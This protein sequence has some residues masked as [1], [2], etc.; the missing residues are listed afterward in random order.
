MCAAVLL[1]TLA[2]S[3]VLTGCKKQESST[4]S[5]DKATATTQAQTESPTL[6]TESPSVSPTDND[7]T[8]KPDGSN[9]VSAEATA[10]DLYCLEFATYSGEFFEDGKNEVVN[11]VAM[12]LVQNRSRQFLDQA[13][14]TYIYGNEY[15]TFVVTGLPAGEKCW[16]MEKNKLTLE[17]GKSFFFEDCKTSFRS[18]VI[19]KP[20]Q[21]QVDTKDNTITIENTSRSTLENVSVYYKNVHADGSYIGGITYV[22]N[23]G[24]MNPGD[25]ICKESAHFSDSAKIV[26]FSYQ[27]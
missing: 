23:F 16:V 8:Q 21:L 9:G 25:I 22:M 14:I 24:T 7:K 6:Q 26:R 18:G 10:A 13:T 19:T 27:V 11:D 4:S 15:A 2:S 12:I 5:Q 1:V 17:D 3:V 20:E